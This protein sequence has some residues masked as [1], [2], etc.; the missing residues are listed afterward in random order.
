MVSDHSHPHD[1]HEDNHD[2]DDKNDHWRDFYEDKRHD[3]HHGH[4]PFPIVPESSV[5]GIILLTL[6]AALV[7]WR[8]IRKKSFFFNSNSIQP[9]I[10]STKLMNSKSIVLSLDTFVRKIRLSLAKWIWPKTVKQGELFTIVRW[11]LDYTENS[12]V[13]ETLRA[14][15]VDGN[16]ISFSKYNSYAQPPQ[17]Q[18]VKDYWLFPETKCTIKLA[19]VSSSK[20]PTE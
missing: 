15:I 16:R 6:C 18:K 17:W 3:N 11:N 20:Y 10:R 19:E 2:K 13:G 4:H 1:N 5:Y 8:R 9:K 14:D 7:I 12:W